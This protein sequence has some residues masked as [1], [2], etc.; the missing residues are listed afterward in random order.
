[1]KKSII[2][3]GIRQD[4][5]FAKQ[6]AYWAYLALSRDKKGHGYNAYCCKYRIDHFRKCKNGNSLRNLHCRT[7]EEQPCEGEVIGRYPVDSF[8]PA[9]GLPFYK[10]PSEKYYVLRIASYK[11]IPSKTNL[12]ACDRIFFRLDPDVA[13]YLSR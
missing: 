9:P 7:N 3:L 2:Y 5:S 11:I 13:R 12:G 10:D 1:M 8:V 6:V 4:A